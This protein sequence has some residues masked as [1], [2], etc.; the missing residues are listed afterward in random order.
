MFQRP[1]EGPMRNIYGQDKSKKGSYAAE[2]LGEMASNKSGITAITKE[3]RLAA[4]YGSGIRERR[5]ESA[6]RIAVKAG[7]QP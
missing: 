6:T 5:R 2:G 7:L 4:A 3:T 1:G